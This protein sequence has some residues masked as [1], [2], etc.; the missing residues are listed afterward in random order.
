M[1]PFNHPITLAL[2]WKLGAKLSSADL[3]LAQQQ[4]PLIHTWL[5]QNDHLEK[6]VTVMSCAMTK[7]ELNVLLSPQRSPH[8][9]HY[10]E[11][12]SRWI[13]LVHFVQ[14]TKTNVAEVII[15]QATQWVTQNLANSSEN[16]E[17]VICSQIRK[18]LYL[19]NEHPDSEPRSKRQ[20]LENWLTENANHLNRLLEEISK[21]LVSDELKML[22]TDNMDS[23]KKRQATRFWEQLTQYLHTHLH[24]HLIDTVIQETAV[25]LERHLDFPKQ[26]YPLRSE[27][28]ES[29]AVTPVDSSPPMTLSKPRFP[30]PKWRWQPLPEGRDY[31]PEYAHH[32]LT[33]P[34]GCTLIAARVRGKK[35]KHEGTHCDDWFEIAHSGDWGIIAVA[36]GAGSKLFSRIGARVACQTA[37]NYL[38]EKLSTHKISP[39]TH[40][41][42]DTFARDDSYRFKEPDLELTQQFLHEAMQIAYQAVAKAHLARDDSKYYYK[43]LGNRDLE[44]SDFASTLLLAIHTVVT[45]KDVHYSFVLTCQIGDGLT[46]ALYQNKAEASVLS[47]LEKHGFGGETEFLTSSARKLERDYLSSK[48]YPFFGPMRVLMVMTDGVADDYFPPAQGMLR[49][50]GDMVLNGILPEVTTTAAPLT[51]DQLNRLQGRK[52]E[53]MSLEERILEAGPHPTP[54]CSSTPY[55]NLLNLSLEQLLASPWLL[56]AGVPADIKKNGLTYEERLQTWLDSYQVRGSFDD[57]TLVILF[58]NG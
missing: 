10:T 38:T 54:V 32:S 39:R 45:F 2:S 37:I 8:S 17:D 29:T 53:Y 31:H 19:W 44:L 3:A 24:P 1:T 56:T 48:T 6:L 26:N 12:F 13:K 51:E 21:P 30:S 15:R 55:A 58:K 4:W 43:A 11:A 16:L 46:A 57:R 40:W 49:L 35:H 23:K 36:D 25:Y 52:H 34:A 22:F 20:F 27:N 50:W 47:D 33:L 5:L 7:A 42:A 14:Q 9:E 28:V 41:S 18:R